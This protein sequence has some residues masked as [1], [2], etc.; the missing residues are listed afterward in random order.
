[1]SEERTIRAGFGIRLAAGVMDLF[2][3]A[4]PFCIFVSFL[5]VGLQ[6]PLAFLELHPGVSLEELNGKFGHAFLPIC[7]AAFILM[8]WIYFAWMESSRW[9][10]T[11][12]KR[13]LGM[14]VEDLQGNRIGFW[15]A[16]LR[17]ATG[18]MLIHL[19]WI[20]GLYFLVDVLW[21][22]GKERSALHDLASGCHVVLDWDSNLIL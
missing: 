1:M 2:L 17:F 5:T 14:R 7:L 10:A 4:I 6:K 22:F 13:L 21:I 15:R 8:N 12:G 11:W 19:P 20:G 16:T 9:Q 3:V 18:R